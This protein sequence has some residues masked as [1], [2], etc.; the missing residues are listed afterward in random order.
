[1]IPTLCLFYDF[2][3]YIDVKLPLK[4]KSGLTIQNGRFSSFIEADG[5][6]EM[7]VFE[8][9]TPWFYQWVE[10]FSIKPTMALEASKEKK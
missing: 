3:K 10:R 2:E 9:D 6:Q 7:G 8:E 5:A 1:M 4:E